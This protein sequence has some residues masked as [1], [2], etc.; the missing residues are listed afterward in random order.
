MPKMNGS[1]D[2]KVNRRENGCLLAKLFCATL[3]LSCLESTISL[4]GVLSLGASVS[5]FAYSTY[6]FLCRLVE[7]TNLIINPSPTI[8]TIVVNLTFVPVICNAGLMDIPHCESHT[9]AQHKGQLNIGW[10]QGRS[11]FETQCWP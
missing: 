2:I 1:Y 6:Y 7:E 10:D 8:P 4:Y 11:L 3:R 9:H 5:H